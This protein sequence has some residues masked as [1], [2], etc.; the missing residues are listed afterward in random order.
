[1][2]TLFLYLT[3]PHSLPRFIQPCQCRATFFWIHHCRTLQAVLKTIFPQQPE[4]LHDMWNEFLWD[5]SWE[6]WTKIKMVPNWAVRRVWNNLNLMSS[7][8]AEE[9]TLVWGLVLPCWKCIGFCLWQTWLIVSTSLGPSSKSWSGFSYLW[10]STT[11][12]WCLC[13]PRKWWA[14][15]YQQKFESWNFLFVGEVGVKIYKGLFTSGK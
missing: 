5:V 3:I 14:R 9:A 12:G 4:L 13:S 8:A 2:C 10:P 15:I 11:G 6:L 1:M 7:T